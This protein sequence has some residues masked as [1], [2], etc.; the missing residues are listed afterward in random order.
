[1]EDIQWTCSQTHSIYRP[2]Q[3]HKSSLK[4]IF[5]SHSTRKDVKEMD[6]ITTSLTS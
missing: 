4:E 3:T 1:M 5:L 2:P 6:K